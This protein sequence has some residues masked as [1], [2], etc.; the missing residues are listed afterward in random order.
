MFDGIVSAVSHDY[1]G[2]DGI[3]LDHVRDVEAAVSALGSRSSRGSDAGFLRLARMFVAGFGDPNLRVIKMS[4]DARHDWSVGF[5]VRAD[6]DC[7][8]VVDVWGDGRL[9][10]GDRIVSIDGVG[11]PELR[12]QCPGMLY[13]DV[14]E[15]E[16]WDLLVQYAREFEVEDGA[17][18]VRVAHEP[19]HNPL[20]VRALEGPEPVLSCDV[21][22][23]ETV[24]LRV[25]SLEDAD[26]VAGLVFENEGLLRRA[27]KLVLDLRH[28]RGGSYDGIEPLLP[29]LIDVPQSLGDFLG[30]LGLYYRYSKG[31]CD[32][33]IQSL[34]TQAELEEW[35]EE[36][37]DAEVGRIK[38]LQEQGCVLCEAQ[39]PDEW[40]VPVEPEE[41][42]DR[43][44]VL[45][46]LGC[47]NEGEQL[48]ASI[49]RQQKAH[50][51]GRPS[52]GASD[53][54]ELFTLS[55]DDDILFV[56][57]IATTRSAYEGAGILGKG[58][59]PD[60]YVPW[61]PREIHED[62]LLEAAVRA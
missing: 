56:Y 21:V 3:S 50:V 41:G 16:M 30:D 31:N 40:L 52:M 37:L 24:Y 36:E 5:R 35:P 59:A 54:Q 23:D 60:T 29:F 45:S 4:P 25:D 20:D 12:A 15:R 44:V 49:A 13:G 26:A 27:G 10:P 34:Q 9:M 51:L 6:R 57:P 32:R 43:V 62:V 22:N 46:D 42:P 38:E 58:V 53:Y 2:C 61:T 47:R 17:T 39:M 28:C 19:V 14:P 1:A 8:Y 55:F 11:I 18:G 33:M 7:L 48:L